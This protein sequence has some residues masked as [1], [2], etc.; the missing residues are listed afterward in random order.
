[1]FDMAESRGA[2]RKNRR[3]DLGVGDHLDAEDVCK[4]RAAIVAKSA[5][6]E[7]LTLLIEDQDAGKH[8][9]TLKAKQKEDNVATRVTVTAS[10]YIEKP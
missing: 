9:C 10:Q 5:K 2:E 3:A 7:V 8:L 1:M 4:A 6:D